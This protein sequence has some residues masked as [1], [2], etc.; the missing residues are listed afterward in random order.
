MF[1][2]RSFEQLS[3]GFPVRKLYDT[4]SSI[5]IFWSF[6]V[7]RRSLRNNDD[8]ETRFKM[9]YLKSRVFKTDVFSALVNTWLNCFTPVSPGRM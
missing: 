2:A 8:M 1:I 5:V 3:P 6:M 9:G 4:T 7:A